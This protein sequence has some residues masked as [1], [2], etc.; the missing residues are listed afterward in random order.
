MD[1]RYRQ[2]AGAGAHKKKRT[3]EKNCDNNVLAERD[4]PR[5]SEMVPEINLAV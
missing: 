3:I 2:F 1:D 5:G 4:K